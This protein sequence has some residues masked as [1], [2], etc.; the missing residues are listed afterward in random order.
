MKIERNA[1]SWQKVE[2]DLL[3]MGRLYYIVVH[4]TR[5]GRDRV[6]V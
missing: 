2:Q 3:S 5:A 1:N 4:R 6:C